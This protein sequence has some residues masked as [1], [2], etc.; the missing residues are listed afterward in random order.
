MK[1]LIFRRLMGYILEKCVHF[2]KAMF[3]SCVQYLDGGLAKFLL[4]ISFISVKNDPLNVGMLNLIW[5]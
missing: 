3:S 4:D 5:K 1:L 2:T